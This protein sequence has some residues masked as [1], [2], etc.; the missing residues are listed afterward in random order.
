MLAP[1]DS[2]SV[3]K[4]GNRLSMFLFVNISEGLRSPLFMSQ[5]WRPLHVT[6]IRFRKYEF[7]RTEMERIFGY[8]FKGSP[9]KETS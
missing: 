4:F 3:G 6:S 7:R 5:F 9:C 2:T 8:S 1:S